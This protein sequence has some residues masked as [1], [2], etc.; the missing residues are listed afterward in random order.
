MSTATL[1]APARQ[2]EIKGAGRHYQI[3]TTGAIYPSVTTILDAVGKPALVPWAANQERTLVMEAAAKLWGEL[4]ASSAKPERSAYVTMLSD[5]LG[6]EKAHTKELAK[7]AEIGTQAHRYIEWTLKKELGQ[8]VT[9]GTPP[10]SPKAMLAYQ[11]F[12][13]WRGRVQLMPRRIEQTVWSTT[14]GYAGTLDLL[15]TMTVN[16]VPCPAVLDWKTGKG[17]YPEALLQNA[18]YV[19]ALVEMGHAKGPVHGVIVR[20]PK[21]DKDPEPE[22]RIIPPDAQAQLL[23]VFLAVK[24]LWEFLQE[25]ER[26]RQARW[27]SN[28]VTE[29]EAAVAPAGSGLAGTGGSDTGAAV[30]ESP[31]VDPALLAELD[32]AKAALARQPNEAQ[33]A[34][35]VLGY[36]GHRTPDTAMPEHVRRLLADVR[37][38]AKKDA[39]A[40]AR[41]RAILEQPASSEPPASNEPTTTAVAA[42]ETRD[43]G[44]AHNPRPLDAGSTLPAE[45]VTSPTEAAMLVDDEAREALLTEIAAAK[46]QL[47]RQPPPEIWTAILRG[48]L[49]TDD[50]RVADP[51]KLTKLRDLLRGCVAKDATAIERV[52]AFVRSTK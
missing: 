13:E 40:I 15:A 2:V 42:A 1:P 11:A 27:Q 3:P 44:R 39:G 6:K 25:Q 26:A 8:L 16:G 24:R 20:L 10:M 35:I 18:A 4:V 31:R 29:N 49:H 37:G 21:V 48:A 43:E 33:W 34:R 52:T 38:M 5:R 30:S 12:N 51:G 23:E 28:T 47:E 41:V 17:I 14:H 19:A 9:G 22:I 32:A 45:P 36:T 7:A 46:G 50:L